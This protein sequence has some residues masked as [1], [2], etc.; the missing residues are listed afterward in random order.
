M[1]IL[2]FSL[3]LAGFLYLS[4]AF[5]WVNYLA[6]MMLKD[7]RDELREQGKDFSIEQKIWGYPVLL[8]M[9]VVDVTFNMIPGT[10]LYL[11][12]PRELLF[13]SRCQRHMNEVGYRGDF[14]RWCCKHFM[15]PFDKGGHC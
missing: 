13:T 12:I 4:I 3:K 2:I 5:M 11:E 8:F 15:D 10:I 7:E 14:A 6:V 1:D 9:V